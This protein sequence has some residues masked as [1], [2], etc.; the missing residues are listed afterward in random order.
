MMPTALIVDDEP[1]ANKLL[2]MLVQLRG[3]RTRSAFR[4]DEALAS[5]RAEPPDIVFLDL[6]LPDANGYDVC[7]AL[8]TSRETSMIPV[9]MVTARLAEE[10]REQSYQL[11]ASEFVPKPYTPDQIFEALATA[12]AWKRELEHHP[13][14]GRIELGPDDGVGLAR[15][16]GQLGSLLHARTGLAEAEVSGIVATL[17]A[18]GLRA[19]AF[20]RG[21]DLPRAATVDYRIR[22]DQLSLTI[23][24]DAGWLPAAEFHQGPLDGEAAAPFDEVRRDEA[25]RELV[26]IRRLPDPDATA[27]A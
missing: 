27:Q 4:G 6:M 1:E 5:I 11:G 14:A 25:G 21:R 23:Q 2:A 8:K 19:A 7:R 20:A 22:A 10:N 13:D 3:Y 15:D 17:K 18:L 9:V 24:G 12:D 16:A 26:L